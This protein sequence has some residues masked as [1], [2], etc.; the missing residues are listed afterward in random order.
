MA[1]IISIFILF[2]ALTKCAI[3]D[4]YWLIEISNGQVMA[5]S[6]KESACEILYLKTGNGHMAKVP[7]KQITEISAVADA[8]KKYFKFVNNGTEDFSTGLFF[9]SQGV[10]GD[11]N[12]CPKFGFSNLV[13]SDGILSVSDTLPGGN[14]I[15]LDVGN[16]VSLHRISKKDI[17]KINNKSYVS[18]ILGK[19]EA[20][21]SQG[22]AGNAGSAFS[23]GTKICKSGPGSAKEYTGITMYGKPQY[24]TITGTIRYFG[25]VEGASGNKLQIRISAIKFSSEKTGAIVNLEQSEDN[26]SVLKI[27][28]IFWDDSYNWNPC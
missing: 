21:S 20:V 3:G 7:L 26:D 6:F 11:N 27:N 28:S 23:T 13:L 19:N 15:V 10:N 18:K 16:L 9:T 17:G 8:G 25:F 2:L 1:K 22:T 12:K 24:N 14:A 4:D 5:G